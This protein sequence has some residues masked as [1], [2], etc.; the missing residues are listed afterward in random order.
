M[1]FYLIKSPVVLLSLIIILIFKI[2]PPKSINSLYGY[3]TGRSMKNKEQW[4]FAQKYSANLALM[5]LS[6][7]LIIQCILYMLYQSSAMT[8]LTTLG[9]WLIGMGIVI[10]TV[11]RKL[12]KREQ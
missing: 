8:D 6:T 2:F 11:E 7:V 3:R 5:V 12:K 9:F 10:V 1:I 4:E